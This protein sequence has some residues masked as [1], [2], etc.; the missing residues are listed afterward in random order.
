MSAEPA[1]HLIQGGAVELPRLHGIEKM[2]T[3]AEVGAI[4]RKHPSSVRRIPASALPFTRCG[5][6]RLYKQSSVRKYIDE[7]E[8][9]R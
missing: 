9:N 8:V 3:T 2:L 7:N 5:K 6:E 1:L 4:L